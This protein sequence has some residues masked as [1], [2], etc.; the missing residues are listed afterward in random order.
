MYSY[1]YLMYSRIPTVIFSSRTK[2]KSIISTFEI[3]HEFD[4]HRWKKVGMSKLKMIKK[5]LP[6]YL[7]CLLLLYTYSCIYY[8]GTNIG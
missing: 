8:I 2:E 4:S 6:P 1:Y 7:F 3:Y 5:K